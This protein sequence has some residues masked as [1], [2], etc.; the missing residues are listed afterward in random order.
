MFEF[1]AGLKP[2]SDRQYEQ[3]TTILIYKG[4]ADVKTEGG[5]GDNADCGT[6]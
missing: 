1:V 2:L 5:E 6:Y 4:A 3:M